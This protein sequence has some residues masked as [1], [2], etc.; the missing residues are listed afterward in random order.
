MA[1]TALI[2]KTKHFPTAPFQ[3]V[4]SAIFQKFSTCVCGRMCGRLL[5]LPVCDLR[6]SRNKHRPKRKQKARE[7]EREIEWE[8]ERR[9]VDCQLVL[10]LNYQ[11]L[12]AIFESFALSAVSGTER[13]HKAGAGRRGSGDVLSY[14]LHAFLWHKFL[15]SLHTQRHTQ[16]HTQAHTHKF[17]TSGCGQKVCNI[18]ICVS[19]GAHLHVYDR[20]GVGGQG[21]CE[22]T[23]PH[24]LWHCI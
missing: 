5:C 17:I 23:C 24:C 6:E 9:R 12:F 13:R 10:I 14:K 20:E 7:R 21:R 18:L 2:A 4:F 19:A 1:Q 22:Q 8:R 15:G 3:N 11:K 16:P